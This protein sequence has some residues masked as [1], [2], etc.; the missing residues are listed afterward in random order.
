VDDKDDD[1]NAIKGMLWGIAGVKLAVVTI[2]GISLTV[3]TIPLALFPPLAVIPLA[4]GVA[5]SIF[6]SMTS[7]CIHNCAYHFQNRTVKVIQVK[8]IQ[9]AKDA[10]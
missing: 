10:G 7:T 8:E 6:G 4:C 3:S 5:T 2:S 9:V 1:R